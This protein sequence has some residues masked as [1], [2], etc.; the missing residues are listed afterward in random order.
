MLKKPNPFY[1]L[2][3][4]LELQDMIYNRFLDGQ[5]SAAQLVKELDKRMR[6]MELENKE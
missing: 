1:D 5:V 6:M 4:S 3:S 2:G